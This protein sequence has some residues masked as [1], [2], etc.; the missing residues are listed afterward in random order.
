[1]MLGTYLVVGW[2]K[3]NLI[4]FAL[5]EGFSLPGVTLGDKG[6][7][8]PSIPAFTTLQTSYLLVATDVVVELELLVATCHIK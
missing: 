7:T 8:C 1:M 2:R 4:R 6:P 5:H 3:Q